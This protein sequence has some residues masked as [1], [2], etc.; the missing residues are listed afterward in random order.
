M[1]KERFYE[2][3]GGRKT[4]VARVRA[5]LN[6]TGI[7][8]NDKQYKEYFHLPIHQEAVEAPLK[9]LNKKDIGITV[10]VYG[11][12]STGQAEAV[13]QG[14]AAVL[15]K[16]NPESRKILRAAGFL[17]RDS[18]MVERKKYGLKKARRAPQWAKR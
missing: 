11:G 8:V 10:K 1:A 2:A 6:K 4:A 14:I 18:R 17:T 9:L 3:K 16:L 5:H 15:V 7:V 12:G 13:R